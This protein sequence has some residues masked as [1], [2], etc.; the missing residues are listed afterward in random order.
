MA[1]T[2]RQ[3]EP[4][5][6]LPEGIKSA[7][8]I[9][10]K[11]RRDALGRVWRQYRSSKMG[12]GGLAIMLSFVLVAIFGPLLAS[13]CDLSPI[14]HP[15]N[16]ALAPPSARFWLGTDIQG[17]SVLSLTI[18]G[19]QVSLIVGLAATVITVVIGSVVGLVAGYYGGW[20][21][22]V[23]MRLTDWFL[24]IPFL[25]LAIVLAVI[26]KPSLYTVIFVI[27][28]TT[29]PSTARVIRAQVLSLKTRA[30]VERARALGAS[31]WHLVTRHILPNV[32]PLIFANTILIVASAILTETTLSFL[33]LGPDPAVNISW[34]TILELAFGQGAAFAGY[35]WWIIPPGVAII[36]LVLAFT[37]IGYAL[38]DILNPKLRTR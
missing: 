29:W 5:I 19:A 10:W 26:L 21:E 36:L 25:P 4:E 38:D 34:G 23:L 27:G 6:Q 22:T 9:A 17:R 18:W 14:C 37:M 24:V 32:G 2:D 33:G 8:A 12:M 7:K 30:Y 3:S 1:V 31:D 28:I 16:P 20:R 11:R 15:D 13:K 35:W